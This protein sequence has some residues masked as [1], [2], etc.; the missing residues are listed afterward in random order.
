MPI[1]KLTKAVTGGTNINSTVQSTNINSTDVK[2]S[3]VN[4]GAM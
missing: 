3:A 1:S 2:I 4:I